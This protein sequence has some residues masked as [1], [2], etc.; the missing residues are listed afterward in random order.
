MECYKEDP[1]QTGL[2]F[3]D[4]E[5]SEVVA[6][7]LQEAPEQGGSFNR[8]QLFN[9]LCSQSAGVG[10]VDFAGFPLECTLQRFHGAGPVVV[11]NSVEL[12]W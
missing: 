3:W 11:K 9:L 8:M 10:L 7:A 4:G 6:P 2:I 1:G 5:F 12:V